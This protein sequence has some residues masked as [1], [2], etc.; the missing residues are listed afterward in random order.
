MV[1]PFVV[2]L[3]EVGQAGLGVERVE[4]LALAAIERVDVLGRSPLGRERPGAGAVDGARSA[5]VSTA[6]PLSDGP[7]DLRGAPWV[8]GAVV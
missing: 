8:L 4:V 2:I 5:D 6:R 3:Q 7:A 1:P